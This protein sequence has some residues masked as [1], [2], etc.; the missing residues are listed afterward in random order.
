LVEHLLW[1]QGVV[2]SN[3]TIPRFT[4]KLASEDFF[5]FFDGNPFQFQKNQKFIPFG[6]VDG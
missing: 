6:I 1:E 3:P 2:G 5:R 4:E